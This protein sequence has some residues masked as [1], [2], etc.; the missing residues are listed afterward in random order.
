[1]TSTQRSIRT[2]LCLSFILAG[3]LVARAQGTAA[4]PVGEWHYYGGDKGFTRYSPLDQIGRDNVG[5]LKVLWRRPK[6]NARLREAFPDLVVDD[7]LKSTPIMVGGVLYAPNG[8][9]LVEAFDAG[10]GQTIWE[11]QPF[12]SSAEGVRGSSSRGLDYWESGTDQRVLGVKGDYLYA[13]NAK[14]GA[15]YPDFGEEGRVSLR[16]QDP[17]A[18]RIWSS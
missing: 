4:Q 2:G 6:V 12:E 7:N 13:L 10:T 18:G 5:N 9:G 14:T 8:V 17:L 1:M 16:R 3:S 15:Y 11:Q